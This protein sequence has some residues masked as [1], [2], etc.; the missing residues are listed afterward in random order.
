MT[1]TRTRFDRARTG[2]PECLVLVIVLA[3][4]AIWIV[5]KVTIPNTNVFAM[6]S[7]ITELPLF[8]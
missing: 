3:E 5:D 1:N 7:K 4:I 8:P 2:T 6:L